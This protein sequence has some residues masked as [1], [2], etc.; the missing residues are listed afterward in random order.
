MSIAWVCRSGGRAEGCTAANRFCRL[1]YSDFLER[2]TLIEPQKVNIY[3]SRE[4]DRGVNRGGKSCVDFNP[5]QD[6]LGHRVSFSHPAREFRG[7][8]SARI[9]CHAHATS[10]TE[11]FPFSFIRVVKF[12]EIERRFVI[13]RETGIVRPSPCR[14]TPP[15]HRHR[16][17]T[18]IIAWLSTQP[19]G[20]ALQMRYSNSNV[21]LPANNSTRRQLP[22]RICALS[23]RNKTLRRVQ[24]GSNDPK[25]SNGRTVS[26]CHAL[27]SN[28]KLRFHPV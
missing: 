4:R 10:N 22:P 27:F 15:R 25:R 14:I 2:E 21:L 6:L 20:N 9:A 23:C 17:L 12:P 24:R 18:A 5:M 8:E 28:R 16:Q 13:C 3:I 26:R 7:I 19:G 11:Q 1:I